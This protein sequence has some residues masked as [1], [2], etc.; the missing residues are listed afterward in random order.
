MYEPCAKIVL[1]VQRPEYLEV[2]R[3]LHEIA[4]QEFRSFLASISEMAFVYS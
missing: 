3:R 1:P 4:T 2:P